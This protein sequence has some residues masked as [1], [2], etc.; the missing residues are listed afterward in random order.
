M[1]VTLSIYW[2]K[3]KKINSSSPKLKYYIALSCFKAFSG[4][5]ESHPHLKFTNIFLITTRAKNTL[6]L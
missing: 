2:K 6:N 4:N 5:T 1:I 3:K